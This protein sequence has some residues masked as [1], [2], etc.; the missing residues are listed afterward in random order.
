MS[1]NVELERNLDKNLTVLYPESKVNFI[2]I[3]YISIL[4]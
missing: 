3:I 1:L 2:A 4:L